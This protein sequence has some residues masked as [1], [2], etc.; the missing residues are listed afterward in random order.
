MLF[1]ANPLIHHPCQRCVRFVR[2]MVSRLGIGL[3][4]VGHIFIAQSGCLHKTLELI[5]ANY[6]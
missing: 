1:I 6:E 2:P 4:I 5:F 3:K